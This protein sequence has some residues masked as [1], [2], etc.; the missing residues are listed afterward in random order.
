MNEPLISII[1]PVYNAESCLE[2]S[3]K[4]LTGQTYKNIEI[5]LV[6]DGSS[7]NSLDICKSEESKDSRI[8][9]ID[10]K[11]GGASTARNAG[12]DIAAGEYIAFLD[13]DDYACPTMIEYMYIE[14][15][16]N[17][18][19]I[20]KMDFITQHSSN[21]DFSVEHE[22]GTTKILNSAEAVKWI[23]TKKDGHGTAVWTSLFKNS[24]IHNIRFP[25][26]MDI[27][28]DK[29]FMFL[30]FLN[31][32]KVA[33]CSGKEYIYIVWDTSTIHSVYTKKNTSSIILAQKTKDI[34]DKSYPLY[35]DYAVVNLYKVYL[36]N[37]R[38][39]F[40]LEKGD[41][42]MRA[43]IQEMIHFL[44]APVPEYLQKYMNKKEALELKLIRIGVP[45]YKAYIKGKGFAAK[46]LKR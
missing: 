25:E 37:I 43:L 5:I 6:N 17:D 7:D 36:A 42:E 23:L 32:S 4:S 21:C 12:L 8:K 33:F 18:V 35:K 1:V 27:A 45:I 28:E 46:L 22:L 2:K 24:I 29:Y 19:D 11:N 14:A 44:K 30:A 40:E 3:I 9:V 39:I 15:I 13:A 34:I 10:K 16:S 41:S 20:V 31:S 38:G 26:G